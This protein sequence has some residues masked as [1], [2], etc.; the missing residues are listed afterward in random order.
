MEYYSHHPAWVEID[1]EQLR[2][3][4]SI[5]RQYLGKTLY[6]LAVKSD[7]YGHGLCRV[8]KIAEEMGVDYLAVA[9]LQEGLVL[10]QAGV[11][12]PILVLGAIHEDQ[13]PYL[14][15][16]DLEFTISSKFKAELVYKKALKKR[17]RVHLEVDIGMHRTGVRPHTARELFQYM[18][19]FDCFEIVGIYSHLPKAAYPED[20]L[21]RKQIALFKELLN[22]PPFQGKKLIRHIA[23]SKAVVHFPESHLDMVRPAMLTFGYE[24]FLSVKPCF[25]LKAKVSYFK[26]VEPDSSI[27]YGYSFTT[28]KKSRIV[29]V[30]V[31]YGDGYCRSLSNRGSVLIR[32]NRF[33]IV[34][35]ICMNQ[36]MVDIQEREVHP[37]DEVVLIGSQGE[38]E[39]SLMEFAELCGTIPYEVLCLFSGKLPRKYVEEKYVDRNFLLR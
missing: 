29:T 33:P 14:I 18:D 9:H 6:C 22:A 8:G 12:L 37:E 32:G 3:N 17:C 16:S 26:V 15:D 28:S 13:I 2:K 10:R 35:T 19:S 36:F 34:G 27:S 21:T 4:L 23:N 20:P 5:V 25:S 1:L 11:K 30:P 31:G 7:A 39:I 24:S 38:E